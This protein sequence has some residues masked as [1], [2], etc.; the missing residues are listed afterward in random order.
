MDSDYFLRL[1]IDGNV[2]FLMV[3]GRGSPAATL[4]SHVIIKVNNGYP[5]EG[6]M[7]K[8]PHLMFCRLNYKM[9]FDLE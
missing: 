4:I 1:V 6:F 2:L 7:F 8:P 3:L 5:V 9:H